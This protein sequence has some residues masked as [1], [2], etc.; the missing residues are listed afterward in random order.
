MRCFTLASGNAARRDPTE[1]PQGHLG[2]N[3]AG[4]ALPTPSPCLAHGTTSPEALGGRSPLKPRGLKP[5]S[6]QSIMGFSCS[7]RDS[8]GAVENVFPDRLRATYQEEGPC[9]IPWDTTGYHGTLWDSRGHHGTLWDCRGH[10]GTGAGPQAG[11]SPAVATWPPCLPGSCPE[12]YPHHTHM[13]RA[14]HSGNCRIPVLGIPAALLC[15][16]S[17]P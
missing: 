10:H 5:V 1:K 7:S 16:P 6:A 3:P 13:H 17:L 11:S 9:G 12:S 15:I 8:P 14:Q 4:S 2:T